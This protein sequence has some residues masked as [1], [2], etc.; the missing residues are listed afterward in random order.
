M[1]AELDTGMLGC[2]HAELAALLEKDVA[3]RKAALGAASAGDLRSLRDCL[4]PG[5]AA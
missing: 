1:S 5:A 4:Q 2:A 3:A